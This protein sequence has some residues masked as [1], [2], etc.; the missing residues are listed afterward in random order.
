M[1]NLVLASAIAITSFASFSAPSQAATVK[2]IIQH[3]GHRQTC[4][5]K[6]VKQRVHG[7]MVVTK[8]RICR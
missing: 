2:H 7:R 4:V 8:K 6:V 5:V 3:M 1:K